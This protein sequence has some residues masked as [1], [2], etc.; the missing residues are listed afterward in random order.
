MFHG[1]HFSGPGESGRNLVEDQQHIVTIAQLTYF[2][3][4]VRGVKTHPSSP[5]NNRLENNGGQLV[6][7][8]F[9]LIPEIPYTFVTARFMKTA[10]WRF[11]KNLLR[12]DF[13]EQTVHACIGIAHRHG[14]K[15]IAMVSR[16]H[17]KQTMLPRIPCCLLVLQGHFYRNL[18]RYRP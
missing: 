7:V 17:S 10:L 6:M 16:T 1:E 12:K 8:F 2:P 14:C 18:D 9:E 4:I 13:T 11:G 5:L 15:S 3:E